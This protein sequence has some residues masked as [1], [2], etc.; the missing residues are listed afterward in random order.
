LLMSSNRTHPGRLENG[1]A[2]DG[3]TLTIIPLVHFSP[4]KYA[5]IPK[6]SRRPPSRRKFTGI[7]NGLMER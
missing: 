5:L 2:H 6:T 3:E 7:D 4:S 1:K